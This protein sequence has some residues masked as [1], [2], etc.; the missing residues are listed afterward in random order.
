MSETR[1]DFVVI[2]GGI[3][4]VS[5][6]A[7]LAPYGKVTVLEAEDGL[8]YH[9]SGRSA[10]LFEKNYGLAPVVA[11]SEASHD[12]HATAHEG[13]LSPRGLMLVADQGGIDQFKIDCAA[14]KIEEIST[15][16]AAARVPVL[17]SDALARAAFHDDAWDIDT[18]RQIQNFAR[19]VRAS[20]GEIRNSSKVSAITYR[21]GIW[22]VRCGDAVH[23]ASNLINAAGA[24]A[25]QIAQLAGI[26][27]IGLTPF[28][29]S[30]ARLPAPGDHDVSAWP[31]VLGAGE[32]WYAK[33]DAGKLL[34]SPGDEDPVD[35]QDAWADDLVIAEGL[36]RYESMVTV[37]VTRVE[38][39]VGRSSDLRSGSLLGN[40][41]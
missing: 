15:E 4:G 32:S 26:D 40:W 18:D 8:G 11:L 30:M 10:A 1:S 35:P 41:I 22:S 34:V 16:E 20:G 6:A 17:D 21:Q 29:R 27:P 7:R 37:P 19:D 28:R 25:D 39:D 2:G 31:M 5:A 23:S 38:M 33:P 3:A 9:A 13:V 14:L 36:A 12:F 24:W